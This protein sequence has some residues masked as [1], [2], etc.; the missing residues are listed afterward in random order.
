MRCTCWKG[1]VATTSVLNAPE[2]TRARTRSPTASSVTSAPTSV[3]TPAHSLPGTNG[4]SA[5]CWYSPRVMS[6]SGKFTDAA[7]TSMRTPPGPG[8]ATSQGP[9]SIASSPVRAV[10]TAAVAMPGNLGHEPG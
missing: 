7:R 8:G 10:H 5:R 4:G 2:P 1:G 6:T 9:T 3:T